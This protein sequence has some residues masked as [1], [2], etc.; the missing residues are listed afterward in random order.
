MCNLIMQRLI[1]YLLSSFAGIL[2]YNTDQAVEPHN[3]I[4]GL[5]EFDKINTEDIP[6]YYYQL[7]S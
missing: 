1:I 3:P 2:C 7:T 4:F 6:V 5:K